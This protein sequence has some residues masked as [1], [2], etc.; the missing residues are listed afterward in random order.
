MLTDDSDRHVGA[1]HVVEDRAQSP[2]TAGR[3][4]PLSPTA[5]NDLKP[6]KSHESLELIPSL[7][8]PQMRPWPWL[9]L[10]SNERP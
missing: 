6:V 5:L 9:I 8:E 2:P 3:N 4:E 1:G 7:F 10:W